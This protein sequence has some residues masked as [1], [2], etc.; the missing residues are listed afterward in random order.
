MKTRKAQSG[1]ASMLLVVSVLFIGI[2][3]VVGYGTYRSRKT[4]KQSLPSMSSAPNVANVKN[5]TGTV[6]KVTCTTAEPG[7]SGYQLRTQDKSYHLAGAK[8]DNYANQTVVVKGVVAQDSALPTITITSVELVKTGTLKGQVS[9]VQKVASS[10]C[11]TSISIE[12]VPGSDPIQEGYGPPRI[13]QADDNGNYMIDLAAGSYKIYPQPNDGYPIL[14]PI[15]NP[16]TISAAQTTTVNVTYMD[17][18]R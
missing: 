3:S 12:T 8:V 14:V 9:C 17:G 11:S 10:P 15:S 5:Y 18:T 13:V 6:V 2:M 16:I 4:N 1:I 7:C